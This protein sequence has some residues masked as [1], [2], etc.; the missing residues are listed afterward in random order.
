MEVF[1]QVF[2]YVCTQFPCFSVSTQKNITPPPLL[3]FL[4]GS[5]FDFLI[6]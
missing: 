3:N 6:S 5:Y 1:P 2:R 4:W